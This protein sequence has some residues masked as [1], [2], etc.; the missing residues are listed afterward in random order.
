[1]KKIS[2]LLVFS[3]FLFA[4]CGSKNNESKQK[5]KSTETSM[6]ATTSSTMASP[7]SNSETASSE[8]A[9]TKSSATA[10]DSTEVS[11][12]SQVSTEEQTAVNNFP[13]AIDA[14]RF[15]TPT[16]FQL[17]GVNVPDSVTLEKNEQTTV[18]FHF[19][20]GG[21][22]IYTASIETIPTKSIRIFSYE[23]NAVRTV[24][25]NTKINLLDNLSSTDTPSLSG[26]LY[27]FEN[28]NG[29]LSLITP[30]YA[31]NISEDQ[32]DVMLEAV[33]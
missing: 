12:T 3:V 9:A 14:E 18:T 8:A 6:T 13:Y 15:N 33:Q 16:T 4:G 2:L 28:R 10:V 21:D 1:M 30:N 26:A 5:P 22:I 29:G 7:S 24:K 11:S 25:V 32:R 31:G 23:G 17:K 20:N 19:K 27:S